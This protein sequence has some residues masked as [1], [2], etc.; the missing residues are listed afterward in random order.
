LQQQLQNIS[1]NNDCKTTVVTTI[2]KQ[3]L[4][5]QWQNINFNNKCKTTAV[6]TIAKPTVAKPKK[7]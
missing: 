2:A 6:T 1:C 5:Q 4:Q 3:Q 7:S